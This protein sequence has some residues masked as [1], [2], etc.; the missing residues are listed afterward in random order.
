MPAKAARPSGPGSAGSSRQRV[1]PVGSGAGATSPRAANDWLPS[2]LL[3]LCGLSRPVHEARCREPSAGKRESLERSAE[4]RRTVA[5]A[6]RTAR[7]TSRRRGRLGAPPASCAACA[8]AWGC[9]PGCAQPAADRRRAALRPAA[10][11]GWAP[12]R[13]AGCAGS[14]A[15]R[16]SKTAATARLARCPRGR[17]AGRPAPGEQIAEREPASTPGRRDLGDPKEHEDAGEDPQVAHEAREQARRI[18]FSD[19]STTPTASSS[20][21]ACPTS[22]R[23]SRPEEPVR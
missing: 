22:W 21:A 20:A 1:P 11:P 23:M 5:L 19:T 18:A 2:S 17:H 4:R 9:R 16:A 6:R 8:C 3:L 15:A 14:C 10:A 7:S 12:T 13:G